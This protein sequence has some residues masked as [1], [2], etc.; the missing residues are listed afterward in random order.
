MPLPRARHHQ[1]IFMHTGGNSRAC[2]NSGVITDFNRCYQSRISADKTI[3]ANLRDVFIY[4]VVIT[5]NRTRPHVN[6]VT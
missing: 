1:F 2:S 3:I 4:A 6:V 5:G